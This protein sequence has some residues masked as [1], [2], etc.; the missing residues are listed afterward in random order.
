MVTR[1]KKHPDNFIFIFFFIN[2]FIY[3]NFF[4]PP[5]VDSTTAL[6]IRNYSTN[7]KESA[8]VQCIIP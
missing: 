1:E 7:I 5:L 2:F 3:I 6:L 4:F 8:G